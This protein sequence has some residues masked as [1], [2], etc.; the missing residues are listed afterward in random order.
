MDN[1][2][3]LGDYSMG[4]LTNAIRNYDDRETSLEIRLLRFFVVCKLLW[5]MVNMAGCMVVR[6]PKATT[7]AYLALFL[8]IIFFQTL[9]MRTKWNKVVVIFYFISNLVGIPILWYFVGGG[10]SSAGILFV[11]Q[12]ILFV[13]CSRG[14]TQKIFVIISLISSGMVQ[15]ITARMANPVFPME[16]WQY[17]KGGSVL[18]LST[19]LLIAFLLLMQKRE[20]QKERE[21]VIKSEK[22]LARSNSLQKN[23]LANMSHEI[24][25]PLGIVMGF[26][27]LIKDSDD[28][29]QIHEYSR[30]ITKAGTTLLAV[31]NDILDYSK[32][33]SGKVDIIEADYSLKEMIDDIQKDI[34]FKCNEKGLK[35]VVRK[36]ENI[37][38]SLYG[39]N[40]RIRQCL[41]N[42]LSNAVKYTEKGIV[43]FNVKCEEVNN[44][45]EYKLYFIVK[46]T[47]KGISEDALPNIFTAFQRLDEGM[48]R[49]IEGTGLG[50][51]I[52]KN[53]L[54]EMNG[55]IEVESTLGNG[56]TF[57]ISLSQKKGNNVTL[58]EEVDVTEG[59][60]GIKVLVVDDTVLNLTLVKKLLE[61][62]GAEVVTID[63]G[64]DALAEIAENKFNVILLDHMMPDMNGVEVFEHIKE[65]GGVN[66]DTPIIMLTANAMSGAMQEYLD[67]GFDGY[68]SKPIPP[69]ELKEI[70]L[71]FGKE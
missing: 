1:Y 60:D 9:G 67:M 28:I 3:K 13:M 57:T 54:D 61:K 38:D 21:S 70:I 2:L 56:S 44:S 46:D 41:I 37:P 48:N 20:Y 53:L 17:Q 69:N 19:T 39:D 47:G 10:R 4:R 31:I 8:V 63:N 40:I 36:D 6:M 65:N 30:D 24:R 55:T 7:S 66:L 32:I 23:F 14:R 45:D 34:G 51:A 25:S 42:V 27:N 52:T 58:A 15:G 5:A 33:E 12:V 50:M 18:G 62:D 29:E 22:E 64:K 16:Q 11:A 35:F 59:L 71:R 49:G 68:L 26:N 43:V